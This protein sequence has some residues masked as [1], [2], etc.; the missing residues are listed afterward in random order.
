MLERRRPTE[1]TRQAGDQGCCGVEA[2]WIPSH[3]AGVAGSGRP[4]EATACWSS[5]VISPW[6][7]TTWE[8]DS[9]GVL[10][11]GERDCLAAVMLPGQ[12]AGFI[13]T[14]RPRRT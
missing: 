7:S 1:V 11:L 3:S 10:R 9:K 12:E 5:K 8:D 6:S 2:C 4:A 13:V 14:P